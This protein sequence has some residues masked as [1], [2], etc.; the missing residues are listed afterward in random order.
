MLLS[1]LT[2]WIAAMLAVFRALRAHTTEQNFV[3]ALMVPTNWDHWP[4]FLAGVF[5]FFGCIGS[6]GLIIFGGF[7]ALALF[8]TFNTKICWTKSPPNMYHCN[9]LDTFRQL[10]FMPL[11]FR[12]IFPSEIV[13]A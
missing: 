4:L 8:L 6:S 12:E 3:A 5:F 2:S 11:K 7:H 10:F 13:H 1:G 9:T